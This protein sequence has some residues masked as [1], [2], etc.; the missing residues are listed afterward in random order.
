[1][2]SSTKPSEFARSLVGL[3][4]CSIVASVLFFIVTNA[5]CLGW[6]EPTLAGVT[7][8]YV[9]ALPFFRFTLAGDVVFAL[10]TFGGYAMA[11]GLAEAYSPK[12]TKVASPSVTTVGN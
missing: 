11:M 9:Q 5:I 10:V 7:R 8:C 6:Y 12:A 4:G 2:Y 3:L 1:M